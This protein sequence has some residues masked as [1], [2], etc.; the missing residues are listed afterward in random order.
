[1]KRVKQCPRTITPDNVEWRAVTANLKQGEDPPQVVL[2]GSSSVFFT[3]RKFI[4]YDADLGAAQHWAVQNILVL[5]AETQFIR[6]MWIFAT[7]QLGYF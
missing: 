7:T 4:I 3:E 2:A 6:P 1:M 5:D